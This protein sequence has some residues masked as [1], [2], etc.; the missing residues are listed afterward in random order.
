MSCWPLDQSDKGPPRSPGRPRATQASPLRGMANR[1]DAWPEA[2]VAPTPNGVP[3]GCLGRRRRRPY[4]GMA[5]RMDAPGDA[6]VAPTPNGVQC[7]ARPW[8]S[9]R[10]LSST[11]LFQEE[12]RRR[13]DSNRRMR[14]CRPL[15]YHLAT[16]PG[17]AE[18]ER[19]TDSNPRPQPWQ[20]CALPLS[21][22]RSRVR[23]DSHLERVCQELSRRLENRLLGHLEARSGSSAEASRIARR[24]RSGSAAE[25]VA[26]STCSATRR[27]PDPGPGRR[28]GRGLRRGG[29]PARGPPRGRYRRCFCGVTDSIAEPKS[30]FDRALISTKQRASPSRAMASIS[31]ARVV[32]LRSTMRYPWRS[33][34]STAAS[35]PSAPGLECAA[36]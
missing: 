6:G 18:L 32:T 10:S 9:G 36:A 8:S 12:W 33:S 4:A 17:E 34:H 15:P 28:I 30:R 24:R 19:E 7:R 5:N 2:G 25:G 16:S 35:S 31:P 13:P 21:Y 22:S 23:K 3:D 29:G 20:G 1:M 11:A 27:A 14:V 26:G